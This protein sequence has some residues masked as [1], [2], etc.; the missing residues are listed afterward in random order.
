MPANRL[1]ILARDLHKGYGTGARFQPILRGISLGASAGETLFLTGPSGGG[2]TTLLSI[3]GCI[4]TP[5]QGSVQVLGQEVARMNNRQRT[6]FRRQHLGFVFQSCN[7]FPTLSALDNLRLAL[8]LQGAN[9][10][11]ATYR[12]QRLLDQVGLGH[13]SGLRPGLLSGGECQRVAIARALA[14]DPSLLF[15][16]EPTAALDANN[17]QGVMTL[18]TRLVRERGV[19]LVVV[20]HDERIFPFADRIVRLEDGRLTHVWKPGRPACPVGRKEAAA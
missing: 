3:L 13:R 10:R 5:D 6:A 20:T 14:G 12:A 11:T 4:L 16:D 7:L 19:T 1:T 9:R 17:G 8:T 2:K 15:A 18:L